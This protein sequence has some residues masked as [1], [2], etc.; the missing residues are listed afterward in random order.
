MRAQPFPKTIVKRN[1]ELYGA[2]YYLTDSGQAKVEIE[3]W[4]VRSIQRKR[5]SESSERFVNLA[6]KIQGVTWGKRSSKVGDFGWLPRIS[7][8]F[9]LQFKEGEEL[10]FGLYTTRLAALRFAKYTLAE[11]IEHFKSELIGCDCGLLAEE[12]EGD[13]A[14]YSKMLAAAKAA[15]SREQSKRKNN[16]WNT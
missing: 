7:S 4:G 3:T 13:I 9:I 14:S 11:E 6:K 16:L 5:Y 15:I 10:P 2:V 1:A 12:I 8:S